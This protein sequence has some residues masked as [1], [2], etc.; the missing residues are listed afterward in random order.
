MSWQVCFR[1]EETEHEPE[2][3]NYPLA[4][5]AWLICYFDTSV[6]LLEKIDWAMK[7]KLQLNMQDR[8]E[9]TRKKR[10]SSQQG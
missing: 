8:K 2:E 4:K 5:D 3:G 10:K 1:A 7:Y 6:Y 9:F